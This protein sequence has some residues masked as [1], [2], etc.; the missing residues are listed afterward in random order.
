MTLILEHNYTL[1]YLFF[2]IA[3]VGGK[4][5]FKV[6]QKIITKRC[7]KQLYLSFC[8]MYFIACWGRLKQLYEQSYNF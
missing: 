4:N 5:T 3:V 7:P 1:W 6:I 2:I 8:D